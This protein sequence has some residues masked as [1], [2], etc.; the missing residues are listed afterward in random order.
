MAKNVHRQKVPLHFRDIE[1]TSHRR[2]R[3]CVF[4]RGALPIAAI[5][6][7]CAIPLVSQAPNPPKIDKSGVKPQPTCSSTHK[8]T[9]GVFH[10][11]W[12]CDSHRDEGNVSD[13]QTPFF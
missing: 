7:A 3:C 9:M 4:K 1:A 12:Q 8:S 13:S 11:M 5:A 6:I 10:G 2:I